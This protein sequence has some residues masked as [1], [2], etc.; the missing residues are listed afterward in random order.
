SDC[1]DETAKCAEWGKER[2]CNKI[3]RASLCRKTCNLCSKDCRDLMPK[4][5]TYKDKGLC[6][7]TVHVQQFCPKTCFN[8]KG[9]TG[10]VP[11]Q[12]GLPHH[13]LLPRG[14]KEGMAFNLFIY[15]TP[16][17]SKEKL[18][19]CNDSDC[20]DLCARYNSKCLGHNN[21][22]AM[23]YPF[24]RPLKQVGKTKIKK[25]VDLDKALPN[26][27]VKKIHIYY[28]D[29]VKNERRCLN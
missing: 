24:D 25:I 29:E 27:K 3:L 18:S 16:F 17:S 6:E 4:C 9:V 2:T 26:A 14:T 15:V 8:C 23:A 19:E 21:D 5:Q 10:K 13:L 12:C 22:E 7:T 20:S 11:C 1:K 28:K